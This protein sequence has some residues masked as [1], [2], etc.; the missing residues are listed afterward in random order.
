ME[1]IEIVTNM[2]KPGIFLT[3]VDIKVAFYSVLIIPR[4]R[5][6]PWFIWKGKIYKLLAMPKGYIDTIQ[7]FNE[8][9]KPAFAWLQELSYGSSVYVDDN[10]L[11]AQT[12]EECFHNVLSTISLLQELIF[13]IHPTKAIFVT[14]QKV[15]VLSFQID[16]LNM[17]LT[18]TSKKKEKNKKYSCRTAA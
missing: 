17:A 8:F 14:T 13:V 7:F 6:Y 2:L 3:S 9:F 4:H 12:F 16:T 10:L 1:S 15:T 18:L 11:L 5:E